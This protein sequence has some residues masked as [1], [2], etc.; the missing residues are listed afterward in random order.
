MCADID[1]NMDSCIH[2]TSFWLW[3][4][5]SKYTVTVVW[6]LVILG[7]LGSQRFSRILEETQS[8]SC[9]YIEILERIIVWVMMQLAW[10][11]EMC[12]YKYRFQ[13][14]SLHPGHR[15]A[16]FELGS[17]GFESFQFADFHLHLF[18]DTRIRLLR[19]SLRVCLCRLI[20]GW[21]CSW[22]TV[23][24]PRL[25]NFAAYFFGFGPKWFFLGRKIL[26]VAIFYV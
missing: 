2:A 16:T 18:A 6:V 19:F 4:S 23:W 7:T 22:T 15:M 25:Q 24:I 11:W 21:N 5:I 20:R 14:T 26:H 1:V 3:V 9:G 17:G 12:L 8:L 10:F 13:N